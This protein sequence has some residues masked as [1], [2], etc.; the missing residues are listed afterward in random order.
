MSA[1]YLVLKQLRD[2][3][4]LIRRNSPDIAVSRAAL[5]EEQRLVDRM[6]RLTP[7]PVKPADQPQPVEVAA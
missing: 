3:C 5:N 2:T 7:P 4:A 6:E 1:E